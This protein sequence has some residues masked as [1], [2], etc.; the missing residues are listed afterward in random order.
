MNKKQEHLIE[1]VEAGFVKLPTTTK[2]LS[3][4][5]S[6]AFEMC[7]STKKVNYI[8]KNHS[9]DEIYEKCVTAYAGA[10]YRKTSKFGDLVYRSCAVDYLRRT[11]FAVKFNRS[12]E[13]AGRNVVKEIE[14]DLIKREIVEIYGKKVRLTKA[15]LLSMGSDD[16]KELHL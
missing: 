15:G 8:K 9:S 3:D 4:L 6:R 16:K 1:S 10:V 11:S 13:A 5:L 7:S 2:E 14:S 12:H